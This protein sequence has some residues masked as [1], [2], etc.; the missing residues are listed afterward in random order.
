LR[1]RETH[2]AADPHSDPYRHGDAASY[3][4]AEQFFQLKQLKLVIFGELL[5]FLQPMR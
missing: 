5:I 2:T 1:L 4:Y 3:S